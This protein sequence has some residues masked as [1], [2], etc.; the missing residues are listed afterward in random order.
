[1]E[2]VPYASSCSI[3]HF[4]CVVLFF[5]VY[6]LDH[7]RSPVSSPCCG[8][9]ALGRLE[10]PGDNRWPVEPAFGSFLGKM[11]SLVFFPTRYCVDLTR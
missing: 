7:R 10:D 2:D 4:V 8:I 1:M 9:A 11:S 5:Y 6:R 3:M